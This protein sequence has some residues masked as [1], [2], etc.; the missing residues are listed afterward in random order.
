MDE[1]LKRSY[2]FSQDTEIEDEP[3]SDNEDTE[4]ELFP[5]DE[6]LDELEKEEFYSADD[7]LSSEEF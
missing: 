6:E 2:L 4:K 1:F 5:D 7:D 3:E